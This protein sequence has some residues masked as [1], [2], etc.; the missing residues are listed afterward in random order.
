MLMINK[1]FDFVPPPKKNKMEKKYDS[2]KHLY[3]YRAA[4]PTP[5][6]PPTKK[7]ITKKPKQ[8]KKTEKRGRFKWKIN[9]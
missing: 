8:N 9:I 2:N 6:P 3:S 7:S 1:T 5:T 4:T